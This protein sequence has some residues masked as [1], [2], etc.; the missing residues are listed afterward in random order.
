MFD[1]VGKYCYSNKNADGVFMIMAH[2]RHRIRRCYTNENVSG[3]ECL[4]LGFWRNLVFDNA[5]LDQ[6]KEDYFKGI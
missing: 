3:A 4:F 2:A 1:D 6:R 5:K